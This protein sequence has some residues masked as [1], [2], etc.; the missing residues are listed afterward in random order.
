[1]K[2]IIWD[3]DDVLNDFMRVWLDDWSPKAGAPTTFS[4][5]RLTRNPP[6]EL[7][8][9]SPSEYLASIDDFRLS[10]RAASLSPSPQ[11]VNWFRRHGDKCHNVAL[12]ATPLCAGHVCAEWVMRHF[13]RWIR[14][15]NFVP[16]R[17]PADCSAQFHA[18]K[19]DFLGWWGKA[20]MVV[21][22]KEE[23][24]AG[25]LALGIRAALVPQPWN[26]SA[27]TL[28]ETLD[29]ITEFVEEVD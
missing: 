25:A 24:I 6:H 15:F 16:S 5:D 7:L 11:I 19:S 2:T 9:I 26:H 10:G 22:D 23:N 20:D 29:A 14:S 1:M 4:F 18:D 13:G 21:D 12:T 3:V 27:R 17:R 8:G 28:T